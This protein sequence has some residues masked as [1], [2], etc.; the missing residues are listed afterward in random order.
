MNEQ[1]PEHAE[2]G[3]DCCTNDHLT[4][5]VIEQ[6]DASVAHERRHQRAECYDESS[7]DLLKWWV[8]M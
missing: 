5:G 8:V 6:V 4:D 3:S 1:K 7:N 2:S